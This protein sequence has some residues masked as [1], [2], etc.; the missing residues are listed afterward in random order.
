M[1]D[2]RGQSIGYITY[3][4]VL[5][6][7][8]V[9]SDG[10]GAPDDAVLLAVGQEWGRRAQDGEPWQ[11]FT[12]NG[13]EGSFAVTIEPTRAKVEPIS[14]AVAAAAAFIEK[15]GDSTETPVAPV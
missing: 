3:D 13:P 8:T 12:I 6:T 15:V 1:S 9:G 10:V 4:D 7:I 2:V 14:S 11:S 5:Y